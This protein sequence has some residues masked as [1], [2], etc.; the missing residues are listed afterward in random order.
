MCVSG[1]VGNQCASFLVLFPPS[2]FNLVQLM[3]GGLELANNLY[4][5][6]NNIDKFKVSKDTIQERKKKLEQEK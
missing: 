6:K 1:S 2:S 5:K 3:V 4:C